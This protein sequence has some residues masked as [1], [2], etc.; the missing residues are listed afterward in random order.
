MKVNGTEK[1]LTRGSNDVEID[2][3]TINFKEAFRKSDEDYEE[4]SFKTSTDSDKIVDAVK[5]MVTDYNEMMS[6][7][8]KAYGTMPY[9]DSSG[10]FKS[11]EPL[12]EEQKTGMSESEIKNYEERAKQG[13]LFGDSTLRSLYERMQQ[14]FQPGGA[15]S[16]LLQKI[17]ISTSFAS[18]ISRF[19]SSVRGTVTLP[20]S[21]GRLIC[22]SIRRD[23]SKSPRRTGDCSLNIPSASHS[24]SCACRPIISMEQRSGKS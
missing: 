2:G 15:D 1:T 18:Q 11:Y 16:A 5:S 19:S 12:T 7:I 20:R 24:S 3:L 17:G 4:I 21:P 14:V 13:I 9:Q 22:T 6:E 8:R 10:A 23:A